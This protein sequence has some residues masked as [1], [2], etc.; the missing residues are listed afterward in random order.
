M[1]FLFF[2]PDCNSPSTFSNL[3]S[4]ISPLSVA[5]LIT[6]VCCGGIGNKIRIIVTIHKSEAPMPRRDK[7]SSEKKF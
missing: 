5:S 4:R 1:K 2:L 3:E 7:I 6:E